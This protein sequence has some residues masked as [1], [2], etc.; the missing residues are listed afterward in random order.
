MQVFHGEE[1]ALLVHDPEI[2]RIVN[3]PSDEILIIYH[4]DGVGCVLLVLVYQ[5]RVLIDLPEYHL[6]VKTTGE[7]PI[8]GVSIH[9]QDVTLVTVMRIHISHLSNVPYL[10]AAIIRHSV[11]LI[12]LAIELD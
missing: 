6:A 2:D 12:I 7:E 3:R 11:E 1:G 9:A 4:V 8:L 5:L 10:Q